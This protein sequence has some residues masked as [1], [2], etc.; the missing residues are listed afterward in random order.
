MDLIGMWK[1]AITSLSYVFICVHA[2]D[3][4]LP[5]RLPELF[6]S[7][8]DIVLESPTARIFL[9]GRPHIRGDIK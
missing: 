8:R 6:E 5:Q 4:F 1:I 3:E 2:L 7:L 9:T